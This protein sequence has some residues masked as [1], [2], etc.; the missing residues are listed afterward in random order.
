ME[1]HAHNKQDK[2]V[3][4]KWV[5]GEDGQPPFFRTGDT[6]PNFPW[7]HKSTTH[8]SPWHEGMVREETKPEPPSSAHPLSASRSPCC[9]SVHSAFPAAFA[10]LYLTILSITLPSHPTFPT[11][12][13][14]FPYKMSTSS[15][16][17]SRAME[18]P[19]LQFLFLGS[20]P[21]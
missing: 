21:F 1:S 13:F 17:V 14:P 18:R 20:G 3:H 5:K 15:K 12:N 6:G 2:R 4:L 10:L 8:S 11:Q 9:S 19:L 7:W 16:P